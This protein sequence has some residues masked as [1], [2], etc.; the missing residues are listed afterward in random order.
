MSGQ[1][2]GE[3]PPTGLRYVL[4]LC[5]AGLPMP[6]KLLAGLVFPG[7]SV[8]RSRAVEDGRDRFRLHLG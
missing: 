1:P 3:T 5:T 6:V 2:A 7:L 4:T 8:F